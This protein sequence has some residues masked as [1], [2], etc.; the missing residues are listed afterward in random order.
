M[1][2][3]CVIL[4][5]L[6]VLTLAGCQ[7][8]KPQNPLPKQSGNYETAAEISYKELKATASISR[9]TP[10]SCTV[11]FDSP[12]SLKDMS[13]IFRR[14]SVDLGYKG[15]SFRFDPDSLPGGAIANLTVSAINRAMS[16]DGL[17]LA[18]ANGALEITG[19]MD[20]G[21]FRLLLD[22]ESGNL[23]KLSVPAEELEI[24]FSNFHFLN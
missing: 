3:L 8:P 23:I 17:S 20:S 7:K 18:L 11:V 13:F 10:E 5:L 4:V 9:E 14:D 2:K 21:E 6:C 24:A 19:V 12:P 22:P 1:R 15:L 16:D